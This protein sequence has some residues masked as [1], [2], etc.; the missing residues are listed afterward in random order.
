VKTPNLICVFWLIALFPL[1]SEDTQSL[2]ENTIR[3]D[4][5]HADL[6]WINSK[7]RED[8]VQLARQYASNGS[9][10]AQILLLRLGDSQTIQQIL[11]RY[12]ENYSRDGAQETVLIIQRAK[13]PLLI[14]PLAADLY[15]KDNQKM[16]PPPSGSD[17]IFLL[18]LPTSSGDLILEQIIRSPEF[19]P[20][21]KDWAK[22]FKS[23]E[24]GD[25]KVF[26]QTLK[27]WWEQ[28]KDKFRTRD[29][30]SIPPPIPAVTTILPTGR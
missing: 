1:Q 23:T 6:S 29:Y 25:P 19:S 18:N 10:G 9:L 13:Q 15:I 17:V 4:T 22:K 7:N 30:K 21:L 2:V 12:R 20:E 5:T 14:P 16:R 28:N 26:A 27:L 8:V 24:F 11:A 3:S